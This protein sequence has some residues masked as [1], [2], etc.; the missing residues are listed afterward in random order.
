MGTDAVSYT[1]ARARFASLWDRIVDERGVVVVRRRG[2]E[3][4]AMLPAAELEGLLETAHLLRSPKNAER[5]LAALARAREGG[6]TPTRLEALRDE[7][8]LG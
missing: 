5:L 3:D 4:I 6:G 1:E 7:V 8:G 2:A